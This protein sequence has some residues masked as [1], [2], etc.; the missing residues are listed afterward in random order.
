[1]HAYK[2]KKETYNHKSN[3]QYVTNHTYHTAGKV[4][5]KNIRNNIPNYQTVTAIIDEA[6]DLPSPG[7]YQIKIKLDNV[8]AVGIAILNHSIQ[9]KNNCNRYIKLFI[10][11]RVNIPE[12][13]NIIIN[14]YFNINPN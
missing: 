10:K 14:W 13:G 5:L 9:Q 3:A 8:W 6:I 4:N 7:I 11:D 12:N 1:M 2:L